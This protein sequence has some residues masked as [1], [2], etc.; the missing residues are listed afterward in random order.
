MVNIDFNTIVIIILIAYFFVCVLKKISFK[1]TFVIGVIFLI[2][3]A[4]LIML[5]N[6]DFANTIATIAYYLL[7]VAVALAIVE[8]FRDIKREDMARYCPYCGTEVEA[9]YKF[10][11]ECGKQMPTSQTAIK[12][13]KEKE[14][15]KNNKKI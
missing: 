10:C 6:E 2:V 4:G 12:P 3:A 8:Y 14:E 7:I 13:K 9:N 1:I 5:E 15:E 11:P